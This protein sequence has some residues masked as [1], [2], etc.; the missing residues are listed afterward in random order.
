MMN[1]IRSS[2]LNILDKIIQYLLKI[3]TEYSIKNELSI[4]QHYITMYLPN[5]LEYRL[6]VN[7]DGYYDT[8]FQTELI[9]SDDTSNEYESMII[10]IERKIFKKEGIAIYYCSESCYEENIQRG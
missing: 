4:V 6:N 8:Y 3:H 5:D 9:Y 10:D 1:K 7:T 2:L